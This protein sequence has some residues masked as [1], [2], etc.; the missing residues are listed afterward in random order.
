[1]PDNVLQRVSLLGKAAIVN[2]G[3]RGIGRSC[4]SFLAQAG[5]DVVVVDLDGARATSVAEEI[6]ALGR[7]SI[8]IQGDV[9]ELALVDRTISAALEA[10]GHIDILVNDV[11]HA[12]WAPAERVSE[13]SWDFDMLRTVK[14]AWRYSSAVAKT[15][16]ERRMKGAIVNIGSISGL[17]AAPLH[18]AYGAAKAALQSLTRTLAVEWGR[19]GI[20]VNSIAPGS[21]LNDQVKSMIGSK[22]EL[23]ELQR[24]RIPLGRWGTTEDIA[25]GVLFLA[26]DLSG[27]ISGQTIVVDG[28]FL[29]TQI[30]TM[31]SKTTLVN[32]SRPGEE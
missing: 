18:V 31:E 4:A 11:A 32:Y 19:H 3:G 12:S 29:L 8:A 5:A 21:I 27:F 25:G 10:F 26:S 24:T 16:M 6:A 1:M 15:M 2:G 7:R 30:Q 20:R 23:I 9:T 22:P 13:E 28:A 14:Y 17:T